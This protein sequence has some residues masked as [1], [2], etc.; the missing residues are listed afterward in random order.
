VPDP[1]LPRSDAAGP[2]SERATGRP[3]LPRW[4]RLLTAATAVAG[5]VGTGGS[6]YQWRDT[7]AERV[8]LAQERTAARQLLQAVSATYAT[9]LARAAARD[10][11]CWLVL[12]PEVGDV[13]AH[14]EPD[15]LAS[16][17]AEPEIAVNVAAESAAEPALKTPKLS[18]LRRYEWWDTLPAP[19]QALVPGA[20]EP[21]PDP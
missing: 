3:A 7:E 21:E 2:I 6:V 17:S 10:A 12:H 15:V 20:V 8:S 14:E 4:A 1:I 19:V 18:R 13:L 16:P 5:T 11:R 9:E